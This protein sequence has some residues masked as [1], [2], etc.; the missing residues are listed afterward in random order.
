MK[1]DFNFTYSNLE[2]QYRAALDAGYKFTTCVQY[3]N[4][5]ALVPA[6]RFRAL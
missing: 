1:N 5:Y 4:K 2:A 6:H 3:G